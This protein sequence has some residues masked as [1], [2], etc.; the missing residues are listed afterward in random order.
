[1]EFILWLLPFL[2]YSHWDAARNGKHDGRTNIPPKEQ[3]LNPPYIMQL[4]NCYEE[5]IDR[6]A[7]NWKRRDEKLFVQYCTTK[8]QVET[9]EKHLRRA[10]EDLANAK[11]DEAEAQAE[12]QKHFHTPAKWYLLIASIIGLAEFPLN[13]LIFQVFGEEKYLTFALAAGLAIVV[14][15]AAHY[16]GGYLKQGVLR[17][18]K[19]SSL[20]AMVAVIGFL[21]ALLFGGV[22]Y[23][24]EQY[25]ENAGVAKLDFT[26]IVVTFLALNLLMFVVASIVSYNSHD[27]IASKYYQNRGAAQKLKKNAQRRVNLFEERLKKAMERLR[28]IVAARTKQFE[29]IQ[30][31]MKEHRDIGQKLI[32]LYHSHN[33]RARADNEMPKCFE[34]YPPIDVP[35]EVEPGNDNL[36]SAQLS[37]DCE[38]VA[39]LLSSAS[40]KAEKIEAANSAR[41]FETSAERTKELSENI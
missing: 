2:R 28:V 23:I 18:G 40:F 26:T 8:Q 25:V 36:P 12:Y 24:R 38:A 14:P 13:S 10:E 1:M 31:E 41:N 16:F 30:N 7:Q 27:L 22:S 15:I 11:R 39:N 5:N 17:E 21:V 9:L 37:W 35:K 33:L 32:S 34:K 29:H 20:T 19:I 4:K 6:L 3:A